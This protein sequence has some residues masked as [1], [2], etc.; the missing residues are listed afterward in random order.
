[1]NNHK[2]TSSALP[3]FDVYINGCKMNLMPDSGSSVCVMDYDDYKCLKHYMPL[4]TDNSPIYP[5]GAE[6]P[7]PTL[8]SFSAMIDTGRVCSEETFHIVEGH[9]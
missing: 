7:L 9:R 6:E 8:G 4:N 1:M 2:C 5:C 3:I